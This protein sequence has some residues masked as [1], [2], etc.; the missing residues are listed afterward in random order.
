[1]IPLKILSQNLQKAV[2]KSYE[3]IEGIENGGILETSCYRNFRSCA[4]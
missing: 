2:I 4:T 1:M 3:F